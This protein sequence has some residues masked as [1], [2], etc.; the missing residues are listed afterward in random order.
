[1]SACLSVYL[2]FSIAVVI[3]DVTPLPAAV[4]LLMSAGS[5]SWSRANLESHIDHTSGHSAC[6][7]GQPLRDGFMNVT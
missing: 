7:A 3:C 5:L 1:M 6:H 2:C 4:S